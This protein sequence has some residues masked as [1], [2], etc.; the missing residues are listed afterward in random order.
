MRISACTGRCIGAK[1]VAM[2]RTTER[3]SERK[4][5]SQLKDERIKYQCFFLAHVRESLHLF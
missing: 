1:V 2:E 3:G 5:T 4:H